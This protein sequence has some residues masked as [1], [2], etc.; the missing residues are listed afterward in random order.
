[1]IFYFF[2]ISLF[3]YFSY[4][5]SVDVFDGNE[6]CIQMAIAKLL[7]CCNVR[8]CED[9]TSFEINEIKYVENTSNYFEFCAHF[10]LSMRIH[11]NNEEKKKEKSNSILNSLNSSNI[12][13]YINRPLRAMTILLY[14]YLDYTTP[15]FKTFTG[16]LDKLLPY[17]L[18]H[19]DRIDITVGKQKSKSVLSFFS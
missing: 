4:L 3:P 16:I 10:L 8:I 15:Y 6:H 13:L 7:L 19:S 1:M 18:V 2:R 5:P 12:I 14:K 9:R 17:V 11:I